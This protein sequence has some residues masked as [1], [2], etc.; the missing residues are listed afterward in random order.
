[1]GPERRRDM[2]KT[3]RLALAIGAALVGLA[4]AACGGSTSSP[5]SS[6]GTSS[7]DGGDGGAPGSPNGGSGHAPIA[8]SDFDRSCTDDSDCE[9]VTEGDVCALCSCP[10]AAIAKSAADDYA[11]KRQELAATCPP[12]PGIGCAAD[13]ADVTAWCAQGSCVAGRHTLDA[14]SD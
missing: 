12:R 13:C 2:T 14:G 5:G 9:V 6:G 10:N 4:A 8:T 11:A 1:M 7:G 3:A